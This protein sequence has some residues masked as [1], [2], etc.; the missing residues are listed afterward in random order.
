MLE[1]VKRGTHHWMSLAALSVVGG[2]LSCREPTQITLN[3]TTDALCP[4]ETLAGPRLVD[5]LIASGKAINPKDFTS[6]AVTDQCQSGDPNSVGTL[7][8]LPSGSDDLTVEVLVVAGVE[9][10]GP[11]SEISPLK[12]SSEDCQELIR[13]GGVGAI[14]GKPCILVRRRLGFVEHTKLELPIDLDTRCIGKKCGEDQS[15]FKGNCVEIGINCDSGGCDQ[16]IT[17]EEKCD[18]VCASGNSEC[19]DTACNCLACDAEICAAT[20]GLSQAIG[21]CQDDVCLCKPACDQAACSAECGGECALA[22]CNCESC[23]AEACTG[24]GCECQGTPESCACFGACDPP[25][26]A[27]QDCD[28]GQLGECGEINN[29]EACI[30]ACDGPT[31]DMACEFGGSCNAAGFCACNSQCL[32]AQCVGSCSPDWKKQKCYQG[33]CVCICDEALCDQECLGVPNLID[34]QCTLPGDPAGVCDCVTSSPNGG[35]G[36]GGAGGIGNGSGGFGG[37]GG[38]SSS[39]SSSSSSTST[40]SSSTSS[41]SSSGCSCAGV[42]CLTG[43][44]CDPLDGCTCECNLGACNT[45]CLNDLGVSGNCVGSDPGFCMCNS[46]SSGSMMACVSSSTLDLVDCPS[47]CPMLCLSQ[48]CSG[49]NCFGSTCNCF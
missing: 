22:Q 23:D 13:T 21:E 17:C 1:S 38:S 6:A 18:E 42:P 49:A 24:M 20:C 41:S 15:C 26:C 47:E 12:L 11:S 2:F 3:I 45:Y 5:A 40:S 48:G 29:Q 31:C 35:G 34:S 39:S 10:A 7:V 27:T 44:V 19:V 25:V 28:F 16:P 37:A 9:L 8:L 14:Q 30:C 32:D 36:Q 33:G 43:Q 46:G 4:T